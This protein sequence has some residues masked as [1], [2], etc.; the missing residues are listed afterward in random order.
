MD[1]RD[2]FS[3]DPN[4]PFFMFDY[5]TKIRMRAYNARRIVGV[6]RLESKLTAGELLNT[7]RDKHDP[8]AAHGTDVPRSIPGTKQYWK[9]FGLDLVAM[10]EQRG[11][12]DFFLTVSPNDTGHTYR[13]PSGKDGVPVLI[14][15]SS[16]ICLL[17]QLIKCP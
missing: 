9:S 3:N 2:R 11:I 16:T 13:Q 7:N 17:S 14:P 15:Q 4:Y 1:C 6:T 12:S 5:M 10:T 8:Y